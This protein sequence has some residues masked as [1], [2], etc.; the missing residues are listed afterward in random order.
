MSASTFASACTD[1]KSSYKQGT[2]NQHSWLKTVVLWRRAKMPSQAG[3]F[4]TAARQDASAESPLTGQHHVV[5]EDKGR[6]WAKPATLAEV[7]FCCAATTRVMQT[8]LALVIVSFSPAPA[9]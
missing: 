1:L 7:E 6:G 8:L 9:T 4:V 3:A 2:R 5:F